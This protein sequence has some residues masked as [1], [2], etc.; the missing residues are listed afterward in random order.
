MRSLG[1]PTALVL[2]GIA[3][4]ARE[5][6]LAGE[7]NT[8]IGERGHDTR[9][10]HVCEPRLVGNLQHR[11]ALLLSQGMGGLG[12]DSVRPAVAC[13]KPFMGFPT[14]K[15]AHV[16]PGNL[17]RKAQ[18]CA[19]TVSL[20][21]PLGCSLAIFQSD[22]SSSPFWKIA[23]SFFESTRSAA[24]SARALS[25]RRNSRSSCLMRRRSEA[26]S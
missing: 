13:L 24:V 3:Q 21:D 5:G 22:H 14:L 9:R 18:P 16:N 10:R 11:S 2:T 25:L 17:T 19:S 7:V 6:G 26:V 4:H 1:A 15:R 23:S 8:F 20:I 12:M